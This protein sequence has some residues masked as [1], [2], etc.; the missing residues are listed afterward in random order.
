MKAIF[1][2]I[3][4]TSSAFSS[5]LKEPETKFDYKKANNTKI[6][7]KGTV[8]NLKH[9]IRARSN[10]YTFLLD[11][12][13]DENPIEF[14][15]YTINWLKRENHFKCRNADTLSGSF[16]FKYKKS[17]DIL[18]SVLIDSFNQTLKCDRLK[19]DTLKVSKP[20]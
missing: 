9:H 18:G 4:V 5:N 13:S 11:V 10:F 8:R 1:L 17:S 3:L 15:L 2:F 19:K 16:L 20:K 14:K 12:E 7:I 6:S